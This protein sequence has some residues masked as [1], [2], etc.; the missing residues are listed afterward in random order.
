MAKYSFHNWQRL[1]S[2]R[3]RLRPKKKNNLPSSSW[4]NTAPQDGI[5]VRGKNGELSDD[6]GCGAAREYWNSS[7]HDATFTSDGAGSFVCTFRGRQTYLD[8]HKQSTMTRELRHAVSGAS[9]PRNLWPC[10]QYLRYV[11]PSVCCHYDICGLCDT[12][13]T[14]HRLPAT[15]LY[16]WINL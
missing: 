2:V 14:A 16:G 7:T 15:C 3:Y 12:A 5:L 4:Y 13:D 1:F 6:V 8:H 9:S 10:A 11:C